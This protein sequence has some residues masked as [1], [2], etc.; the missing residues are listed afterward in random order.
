MSLLHRCLPLV[1]GIAL[2]IGQMAPAAESARVVPPEVAD[3]LTKAAQAAPAD[4]VALL[5]AWKGEPQALVFLARGQAR[6]RVAQAGERK[7]GELTAAAG[8]FTAALNLDPSLRSAHLGLAQLAAARDDWSAA[9]REAA[10]AQDPESPDKALTVFLAQ[11][12]LRA[13]DWR[14]ASLAAQQ[15]ILRFPDE[16]ALRRVELS[17]LVHAGRAEDARQAVLALLARQPQDGELW[18]HLAWAAHETR[19]DDEALGALELVLALDPGNRK[20]RRQLAE[21]QLGQGLPQAALATVRPLVND[22]AATTDEALVLLASRCAAEAGDLAQARAWL[23]GVPAE[24][25]TRHLR[26][27]AARYAVQA[28]DAVAATAT[29]DTL[30]GAGEADPAVLTWAASLAESTGAPARAEALYLRAIQADPGANGPA[31]L[32]LAAFYLARQRGDEART[33]LATYLVRKPDDVQAKAL[34][35]QWNR[36]LSP[37]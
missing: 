29:L 4:A 27:A 32:R 13:G 2:G 23:A 21:A 31:S 17:V 1:L 35:A 6:W 26:L 18:Q 36:G 14:L 3:L 22:P 11:A 34:L 33:V 8:D 37:R 15:G 19:R 24:R 25:Q 5:D 30:I 10:A 12:A 9:T 7:P 16:A 20:H 28:G